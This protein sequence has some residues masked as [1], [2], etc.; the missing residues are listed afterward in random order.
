M[1]W[2]KPERGEQKR[3]DM[4][5]CHSQDVHS[6]VA[7]LSM[8]QSERTLGISSTQHSDESSFHT[9]PDPLFWHVASSC[10]GQIS[11]CPNKHKRP[12]YN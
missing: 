1:H 4:G 10:K 7:V 6:G 11:V 8:S 3:H 12:C 9:P 5:C 2:I